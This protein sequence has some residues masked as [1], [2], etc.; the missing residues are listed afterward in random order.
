MQNN[1]LQATN[2]P[3]AG[4]SSRE[5]V[6]TIDYICAQIA[7]RYDLFS[8]GLPRKATIL[9]ILAR[10]SCISCIDKQFRNKIYHRIDAFYSEIHQVACGMLVEE[11]YSSLVRNGHSVAISTEENVHF[12]KVDVFII[13]TNYGLNLHSKKIEIAVEVKGGYSLSLPQIFRYLLDNENRSLILWRIRNQQVI[14]FRGSE[15]R[16]LLANF[17][18]MIVFRADRL[19]SNPEMSCH[20]AHETSNWLPTQQQLQEAFSNFSNG[21][22]KTL[23]TVLEAIITILNGEKANYA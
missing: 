22:V 18:R 17:A 3:L 4:S 1:D 13:P 16:D 12:G 10:T 6:A 14:N 8:K 5:I 9:E 2:K 21:I 23:P 11:L 7:D 15:I 20:H 19:L